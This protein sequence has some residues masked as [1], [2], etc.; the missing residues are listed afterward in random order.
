MADQGNKETDASVLSRLANRGEDA[1]T[2]VMD[3]L[4]RNPRVTDALAKAMGAKGKVDTTTRKTLGQVGLAAAGEIGELRGRLERLENRLAA[5]EGSAS[6]SAGAGG[7]ASRR[8]VPSTKASGGT[9]K[10]STSSQTT[11]AKDT[12]SSK[13][14]TAKGAAKKSSGG[15]SSG[16]KS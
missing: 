4:G 11:S 3:E 12:T 2:R 5:L 14:G 9:T 13:S 7:G 1:L 15:S 8:S 16:L 10:K 6:G